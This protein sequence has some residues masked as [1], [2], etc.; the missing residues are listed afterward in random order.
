MF[1]RIAIYLMVFSVVQKVVKIILT[2]SNY[3]SLCYTIH[4]IVVHTFIQNRLK[5]FL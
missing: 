4:N 5:Q 3:K 1:R 2:E